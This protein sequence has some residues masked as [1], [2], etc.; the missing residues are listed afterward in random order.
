MEGSPANFLRAL[1][2]PVDGRNKVLSIFSM[3]FFLVKNCTSCIWSVW[4]M[5][6]SCWQLHAIGKVGNISEGFTV[7][8]PKGKGI[9]GINCQAAATLTSKKPRATLPV[10]KYHL[11]FRQPLRAGW[12]DTSFLQPSAGDRHLCCSPTVSSTRSQLPPSQLWGLQGPH[13]IVP[14]A[15]PREQFIL[16]TKSNHGGITEGY[17]H[18]SDLADSVKAAKLQLRE[19]KSRGTSTLASWL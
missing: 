4:S 2:F 11:L 15:F 14:C 5:E 1:A 9:T 7:Y 13:Y 17:W 3:S 12:G 16:S 19:R 8:T 18:V 10:N 6:K